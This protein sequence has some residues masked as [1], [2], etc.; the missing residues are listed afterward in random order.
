MCKL[1]PKSSTALSVSET[2]VSLQGE[3]V[4]AGWPC[5]F[6]R[7]SGCNL[8][9]TYCD[10]RYAYN[11][12]EKRDIRDLIDEWRKSRIGLVQVTG[13]EPLLQSE[14]LTLLDGLVNEGAKVLLETNG[15]LVLGNV[16]REVIKIVDR[17]T[18][19]SGM[20]E[21]FLAENLRWLNQGDQLKFVITD[22]EDYEWAR[23]EVIRLCLSYYTEVLFSPA[24]GGPAPFHLAEWIIA[25][26]LSVRFQIQL[27]KILWGEKKGT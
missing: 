4:W 22:Q 5:F 25:D 17:K 15:S 21:S 18:P 3:G 20:E 2:F 19:G 11:N 10:T 12:G 16:P 13:G 8:R 1:N 9:C 23:E 24:W 7:L 6:I 14:T 26:R 27:H